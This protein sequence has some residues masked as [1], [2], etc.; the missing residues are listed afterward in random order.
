MDESVYRLRDL[1]DSDFAAVARIWTANDAEYPITEEE[2]R[3]M[4]R[5]SA[6]PRFVQHRRVVELV[7]EGSVVATGSLWQ[8]GL[9]YDPERAWAGVIVDPNHHRRGVGR[10][11]YEDLEAAARRLQLKALWAGVRADDPRAVAFFERAG[12]REKRRRWTSRLEV[13]TVPDG[14]RPRSPE[15]W[16]EEGI[17]FTTI[18]EEGPDRPEVRQRLFRAFTTTIS[19]APH[20]GGQTQYT[21]DE[22]ETMSFGGGPGYIPE[23][24]FVARVG[25]EYV[26]YS[27]LFR[28]A[29]EP[30]VLHVSATATRRE[31][32][33]QGL[34]GEL[35]RRSIDFARRNGYRYI[36]TDNDSENERIWSINRQLGFRQLR[37]QILGEKSL[38]G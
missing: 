14:G 1:Q 28:H 9:A 24:M 37:I 29:A 25:D 30:E 20:I 23:G 17:V 18:G 3:L 5:G 19:D 11:L 4:Y 8:V 2:I 31:Y 38:E 35:K 33:G 10:R 22:F 13:S 6:Q 36:E 7:G 34:A 15:R 27:L 12:F 21:F 32:R 16:A 26:A